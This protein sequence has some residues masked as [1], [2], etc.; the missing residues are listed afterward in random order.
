MNTPATTDNNSISWHCKKG[1]NIEVWKTFSEL[2]YEEKIEKLKD[3]RLCICCLG[4][5]HVA[6]YCK[7][8]KICKMCGNE[9]PT[10]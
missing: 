7:N 6:I 10:L 5:G 3:L 4:K 2:N 9:H 1:H 8:R